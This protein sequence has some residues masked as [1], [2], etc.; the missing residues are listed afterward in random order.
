METKN[1]V[2][3]YEYCNVAAV[4]AVFVYHYAIIDGHTVIR[5]QRLTEQ[6]RRTNEFDFPGAVWT[7]TDLSPE[8]VREHCEFIGHYTNPIKR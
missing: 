7:V 6:D 5:T 4:D 8:W 3:G 1:L 2:R